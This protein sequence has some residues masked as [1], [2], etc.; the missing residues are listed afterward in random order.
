MTQ[1]DS[2][3]KAI[4]NIGDLI[5]EN[6][7]FSRYGFKAGLV[8]E[9]PKG[10]PGVYIESIDNHSSKKIYFVSNKDLITYIGIESIQYYPVVRSH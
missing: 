5:I 7:G 3:N 8:V 10:I 1:R 4:F 2:I 9:I 6:E